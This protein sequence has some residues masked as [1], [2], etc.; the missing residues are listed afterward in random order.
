MASGAEEDIAIRAALNGIRYHVFLAEAINVGYTTTGVLSEKN[1]LYKAHQD[2]RLEDDQQGTIYGEYLRFSENSE[3]YDGSELPDCMSID[4][5]DMWEAHS[6][7]RMDPKYFLFKKEEQS[8]VPEGWIKVPISEVMV[9]REN[10]VHPEDYPDEPVVV[11]TL[12]QTGDNR[13]P[14]GSKGNN[15]FV[16][17][18]VIKEFPI[19]QVVDERIDPDFLSCLLRSRYYQMA[20][21]A[22]TTGHSN[23]RRTQVGDFESLEICFPENI[24]TQKRLVSEIV[25][26]RIDLKESNHSLKEAWREFDHVIDGRDYELPQ[27]TADDSVDEE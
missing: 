25:R 5:V 6:S 1:D 18:L 3:G 14:E 20:F 26:A 10:I 27:V 15:S 24:D 23:R 7:H 11:M 9:R 2:G 8:H 21:R 12:S 4:V 17:A 13:P 19:N 22:I 16:R